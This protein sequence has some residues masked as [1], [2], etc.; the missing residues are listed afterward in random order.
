[1]AEHIDFKTLE[2]PSSP[3]TYLLAPPGL[4]NSAEPDEPSPVFDA[5]AS[6]LFA[7]VN[8]LVSGRDNWT[9]AASDTS[10]MQIEAVAATKILK[11]KDDVTIRVLADQ[12]DELKS[13]LA[14][15]SRSRVGYSDLGANRKR[16]QKLVEELKARLGKTA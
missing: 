3:N 13:Q 4:C 1:M 11:F 10:L 8:E 16:V 6:A 12:N 7:T 2:R 14:I 9:V 5:S 15:Y